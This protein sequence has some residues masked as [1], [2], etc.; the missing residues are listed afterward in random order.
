M[1]SVES[2][3]AALEAKMATAVQYGRLLP[4]AGIGLVAMNELLVGRSTATLI[5]QI[6]VFK[7][8]IT[9]TV[10]GA[11]SVSEQ[12]FTV[13]GLSINDTVLV[14][15]PVPTA[16]ILVT[17]RVSAANQLALTFVNPTALNQT[18]ANGVYRVVA[19]RS[20]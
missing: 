6:A 13:A 10:L 18:P 20:S 17:A 9:P 4:T 12:F 8:S 5:Q 7:P 19:I 16:G 3:L 2:R 14:D 1:T 15:G 11:N